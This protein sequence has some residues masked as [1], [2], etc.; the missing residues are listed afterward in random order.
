MTSDE[1]Y[2]LELREREV[3][4]KQLDGIVQAA[5]DAVA[6]GIAGIPPK[7]H[8]H[9]FYGASAIH[10]RHLTTWFVFPTDADLAQ[11]QANGLTKRIDKLTRK[12]LRE[13][14]YPAEGIP[15][16]FVSFTSDETVQR[17]AGG[18]YWQYFK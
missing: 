3:R 9:T 17:E 13:Y 7:L 18:N 16:V 10:P 15:E 8:H 2:R 12:E 11:A 4:Q 14:G 5:T 6:R 1:P